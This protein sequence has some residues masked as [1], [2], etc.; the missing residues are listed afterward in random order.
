MGE[1]K[2]HVVKEFKEAFSLFDLDG[3]GFITADELKEAL[4]VLGDTPADQVIAAAIDEVDADGS[5]TIDFAEFLT[6]MARKM[7]Q[8]EQTLELLSA[9][10]IIDRN[11]DGLIESADIVE[12]MEALGEY[13]TLEEVR[14]FHHY[15]EEPSSQVKGIVL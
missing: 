4:K 11:G 3:D 14:D 1:L 5:K 13:I 10:K 6:L 8:K 9:F 12:V 15:R 2:D 7:R